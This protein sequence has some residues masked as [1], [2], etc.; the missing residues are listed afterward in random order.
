MNIVTPLTIVAKKLYQKCLA[1][2]LLRL[3]TTLLEQKR[4]TFQEHFWKAAPVKYETYFFS[5]TVYDH[6]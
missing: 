1:R 5:L 2:S 4:A 3:C 6:F